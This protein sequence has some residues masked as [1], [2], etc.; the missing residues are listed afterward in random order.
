MG[1]ASAV[2][3]SG[4]IGVSHASKKDVDGV[5]GDLK[6]FTSNVMGRTDRLDDS[7]KGDI[8]ESKTDITQRMKVASRRMERLEDR[9]GRLEDNVSKL[10]SKEDL[11]EVKEGFKEYNKE[12]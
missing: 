6:E 2:A 1:A 5:K 12:N 4:I 10:A 3:T 7:I 9:F 11:N 8:K